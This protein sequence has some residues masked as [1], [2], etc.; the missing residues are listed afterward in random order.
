MADHADLLAEF[1]SITDAAP[2]VAESFL[3]AHDWQLEGAL[4]TFFV[5]DPAEGQPAAPAAAQHAGVP[6]AAQGMWPLHLLLAHGCT[7]VCAKL[8]RPIAALPAAVCGSSLGLCGGAWVRG[9]PAAST[10]T[11]ICMQTGWWRVTD[12]LGTQ[13]WHWCLCCPVQ[14]L[15]DDDDAAGAELAE[16]ARHRA[17]A[18]A[19]RQ[20]AQQAED[21]T[22][23][24]TTGL[25][26]SRMH[27]VHS[28][29]G[30]CRP[31][32]VSVRD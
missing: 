31:L 12:A 27:P 22:Q 19:A 32:P 16:L 21:G 3:A 15:D 23:A 10:V 24:C 5:Q 13:T 14:I 9:I 20:Q 1:C 4:N 29:P 11:P 6:A 7:C 2:S 17:S 18:L 30:C 28:M 25:F 26:S 8:T